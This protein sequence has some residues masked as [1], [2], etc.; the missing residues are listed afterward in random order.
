MVAVVVHPDCCQDIQGLGSQ[1]LYFAAQHMRVR[2]ERVG[3]MC[4]GCCIVLKSLVFGMYLMWQTLQ[5]VVSFLHAVCHWR[6]FV[7]MSTSPVSMA[8][9]LP[10]LY[11]VHGLCPLLGLGRY[12]FVG[13]LW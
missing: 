2:I 6:R 1:L 12:P 4:M 11:L 8:V 13:V 7:P 5:R 10:G 3:C 9:R